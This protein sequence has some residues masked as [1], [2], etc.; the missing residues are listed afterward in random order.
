[1]TQTIVK[2]VVITNL[3]VRGDGNV[4]PVRNVTQVY[5]KDGILIAEY[6]SYPEVLSYEDVVKF[7][8][9]CEL[10]NLHASKAL[11]V[12]WKNSLPV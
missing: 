1:M 5:E 12:E 6:D 2:E 10:R 4:T 11:I 3:L 7:A 9:W 8:E